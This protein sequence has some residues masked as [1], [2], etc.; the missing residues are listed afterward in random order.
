MA[1]HARHERLRPQRIVLTGGPSPYCSRL[2]ASLLA[3]GNPVLTRE[4]QPASAVSELDEAR[5]ELVVVVDGNDR[6]EALRLIGVIRHEGRLPVLAATER[7]DIEWTAAAVAAGACGAI[8]GS[9]LEGLRAALH[10]A[11]EHFVELRRLEQ[12]LERRAVIERAKGVLMATHGIKGEDAYVLLRNHSKRT[13]QQLVKIADAIL[14]SHG[15]LKKQRRA[16]A[17]EPT[18]VPSKGLAPS[19]LGPLARDLGQAGDGKRTLRA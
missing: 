13:S 2:S 19:E 5:S 8:I 18:F 6:S 15:L 3:L 10:V 4:L 16:A 1:G 12:A 11:C 14:Q 9:G 17:P 7:G